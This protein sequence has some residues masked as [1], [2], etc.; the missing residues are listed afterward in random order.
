VSRN[1]P[2]GAGRFVR[3]V[4]SA[5]A[6]IVLVSGGIRAEDKPR[7]AFDWGFRLRLRQEYG[8]NLSDFSNAIADDNNYLRVRPQLW[9]S[10]APAAQWK[11]YA[12][13]N[14]EH[15]HWYKSNKGL[16]NRK[17]EINELIF[18]NLYIEG[19]K[20]G[21]SPFG[22]TVGRQNLFY[23][24][25]F[26]CWDGG[27][28]DGSRTAYFNALLLTASFDKR[29][30]E[31]HFIS[32]PEKDRYLPIVNDQKQPL[33]EWDETGAG[34][35][36]TDESLD[37]RKLEAYYFYKNEKDKDG[38]YPESDIHTIGARVSGKGFE[39]FTFAVEGAV[40]A[41]DRGAQKR[42]GYGGYLCGKYALPIERGA[43]I[44]PETIPR[45]RIH[46]K[47]GIRSIPVGRN[48]ASSI[49]I[50]SRGNAERR[51]GRTSPHCGSASRSSRS[52]ASRSRSGSTPCGRPS[53]PLRRG[54]SSS[55]REATAEPYR[56]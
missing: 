56:S 32:D 12:M 10:W 42:F 18:E 23:G 11:L 48:G 19:M 26:I 16:E 34:L 35:Y 40:Q 53:S 47:G 49:S 39:R 46:M 29:R 30:L 15:R 1:C 54:R 2:A 41:G 9:G 55:A 50:L 31:A 13:L 36:Y 44:S 51:T 8:A 5:V 52:T 6:L 17:F 45:A 43:S 37:G 27:P 38:V 14:N 3:H 22:F 20:I 33:I 28:L 7:S 25:G 24:E 21:G 4:S